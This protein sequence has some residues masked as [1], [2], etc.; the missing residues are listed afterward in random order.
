MATALLLMSLPWFCSH[1][2]H[3]KKL[4]VFK[5]VV[6]MLIIGSIMSPSG[7]DQSVSPHSFKMVIRCLSSLCSGRILGKSAPKDIT[8]ASLKA[9]WLGV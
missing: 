4:V 5:V 3:Q 6:P 7:Q 9:N 1:H 2:F 8:Q